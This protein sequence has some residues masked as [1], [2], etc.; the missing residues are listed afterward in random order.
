MH[1]FLQLCWIFTENLYLSY[2][3]HVNVF[4]TLPNAFTWHFCDIF[5]QMH[6]SIKYPIL[7]SL[8]FIHDILLLLANR[9]VQLYCLAVLSIANIKHVW[10]QQVIYL[11]YAYYM[12]HFNSFLMLIVNFFQRNTIFYWAFEFNDLKLLLDFLQN[13]FWVKIGLLTLKASVRGV[14]AHRW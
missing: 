11:M 14:T 13:K 9:F 5:T 2:N 3:V 10:T 8:I 1:D 4:D 6:R 7:T 12:C